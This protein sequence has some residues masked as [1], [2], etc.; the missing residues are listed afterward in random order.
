VTGKRLTAREAVDRL[1]TL[2]QSTFTEDLSSREKESFDRLDNGMAAPPRSARLRWF[3]VGLSFA[4]I[5]AALPMVLA[6]V[7]KPRHLS[8]TVTG[9]SPSVEDV[10]DPQAAGRIDFSDGSFVA[11]DPSAR[12][13]VTDINNH[14]AHVHLECGEIRAKFVPAHG[15]LWSLDAGPYLV[16][17]AESGFEVAWT[18]AERTME[19]WLRQG[20]VLIQGPFAD[21]G[22]HVTAGQ[23]FRASILTGQVAIDPLDRVEESDD[24]TSAVRRK[25]GH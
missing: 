9:G 23:H 18:P 11:L 2:A 22:I 4:A 3:I 24:A 7:H 6:L 8:F 16:T 21:P 19:L 12:A 13:G 17:A 10:D 14:G 5:V 25:I 15:T 1:V 20:S